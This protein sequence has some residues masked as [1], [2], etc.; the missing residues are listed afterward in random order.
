MYETPLPGRTVHKAETL[1]SGTRLRRLLLGDYGRVALL[2]LLA[3]I[4]TSLPY[5]YAYSIATPERIFGGIVLNVPDNVQYFSW[6]RDH[7]SALLVSNRMTAEPNEPALFNLLWLVLA[8]IGLVTGW[9]LPTL[10][11][12][13]RVVAG[14]SFL[15]L[16]WPFC[17][18]FT[19]DRAE[20]WTAYLLIAVGGGLGWIWVVHKYVFG[21]ADVAHP[22]DLY[23]SEPNAFFNIMAFPHFMVAAVLICAIFYAYLEALRRR[24][25]ALAGLAAFLG[26]TLTLQHAYDLLIIVLVPAGALGLM[27]LRDRR[28]PWFGGFALA[29]LSIV[30][31]PP[32]LYF[33]W[34]TSRDPLWQ[35]VLAQFSLA[36]IFTPGPLHLMILM[37][38]P[39]V[40]VLGGLIWG[41]ASLIRRGAFQPMR[42]VQHRDNDLFLWAWL[43]IGFGLLYIPTDFQIH[44][45][46]TWQIPVALIAARML[47]RRLIPALSAQ[48]PALARWVPLL[49]ILAVIPVNLYL[50]AWRVIDL[51]RQEAPFY[52]SQHE[53]AALNWLAA[54]A[55][56]SQ[57]VFSG[58]NLGQY[59]PARSD[60]RTFLGHWA[61]TVD[62]LEK[63]EQARVFFTP[64]ADDAF[65]RTLLNDFNVTFL[66]HGP[67]ERAFGAFDPAT[68]DYLEPAFSSGD[69]TIYRVTPE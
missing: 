8:Q 11:H 54:N 55:D 49:V 58:L 28:I 31:A 47:H 3:L 21:L 26:I 52:L 7:E 2:T 66:I 23:V 18:L 20:R 38:V 53:A 43:V 35:R 17:G 40:I 44:M 4:I 39:L 1:V 14:V 50:V 51:R 33:A 9:E 56:N 5:L 34:L 12:L 63:R 64:E 69:V 32:P 68:L 25:W 46:N 57:V 62:F 22:L 59:V 6:F 13:L 30:S 19:R 61:Q 27:L 16:L 65:R 60:A 45:L 36:G 42:A 48:R 15:V 10:Y 67:E 37:G 41:G 29:L 24:S